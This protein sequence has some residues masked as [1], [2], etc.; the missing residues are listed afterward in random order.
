MH[1]TF[2]SGSYRANLACYCTLEYYCALVALPLLLLCCPK[3]TIHQDVPF[4]SVLCWPHATYC[5]SFRPFLH[6]INVFF[7]CHLF[8][9]SNSLNFSSA[10]QGTDVLLRPLTFRQCLP[11]WFSR[12]PSGSQSGTE[13][14]ALSSLSLLSR[15]FL[16]PSTVCR[17]VF[18]DALVK[19]LCAAYA[20]MKAKM[21]RKQQCSFRY[22]F[23]LFLLVKKYQRIRNY[24]R[25]GHKKKNNTKRP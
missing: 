10:Q 20:D 8:K 21:Y 25:T 24:L 2:L 5:S 22:S 1:P 14:M 18:E 3:G 16:R 17:W 15:H 13:K 6:V 9:R 11:L 4:T 19:T 12:R 7:L 23:L